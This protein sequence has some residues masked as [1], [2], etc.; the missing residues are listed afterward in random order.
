MRYT[1]SSD[2]SLFIEKHGFKMTPSFNIETLFHPKKVKEQKEANIQKAKELFERL[3]SITQRFNYQMSFFEEEFTKLMVEMPMPQ[4][5]PETINFTT[6]I[7]AAQ[8]TV[9]EFDE[10]FQKYYSETR[11]L[12]NEV[13]TEKFIQFINKKMAEAPEGSEVVIFKI[14][15][16][17]P[18][19]QKNAED[20]D[21]GVKNRTKFQM[22]TQLFFPAWFSIG[23]NLTEEELKSIVEDNCLYLTATCLDDYII[24]FH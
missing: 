7:N 5:T 11:K 12:L 15:N 4:Y 9:D 21:A 13:S 16:Y 17:T 24:T 22:I 20:F 1:P 3:Q 8:K 23:L 18:Y 19:S 6:D 10:Y 14:R 2:V